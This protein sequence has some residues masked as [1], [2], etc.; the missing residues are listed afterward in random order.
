[1]GK[2]DTVSAAGMEYIEMVKAQAKEEAKPYIPPKRIIS[3]FGIKD[4]S[5]REHLIYWV[6]S[7]MRTDKRHGVIGRPDPVSPYVKSLWG[8]MFRKW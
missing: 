4:D 8:E 3:S 6:V 2:Y 7:P 5:G 1:M